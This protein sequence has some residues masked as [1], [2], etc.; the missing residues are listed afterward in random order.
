MLGPGRTLDVVEF[1]RR[2]DPCEVAMAE[3]VAATFSPRVS[4]GPVPELG[5]KLEYFLGNATGNAHNIQRSTQMLSQLNRIGL[6]DNP[7]TPQYL[8]K[9]LTRL[10][11]DPSNIA[12]V[13]AMGRVVRESLLMGPTGGLKFE[14][15]WEGNKLITGI[16]FGGPQ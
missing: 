8:T 5:R 13:E 3:V 1:G 4:V 9:H 10:I 16:F 6:S 14:T 12:R 2:I 11:N 15:I 7:A